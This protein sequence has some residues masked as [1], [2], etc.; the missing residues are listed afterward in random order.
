ML[1]MMSVDI[2]KTQL[3]II[4]WAVKIAVEGSD[5]TCIE[6]SIQWSL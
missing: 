2:G 5:G 3:P 1:L 4:N 6:I